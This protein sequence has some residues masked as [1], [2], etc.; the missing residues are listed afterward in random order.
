[1]T[2]M[3]ILYSFAK[4]IYDNNPTS[5]QIGYEGKNIESGATISET[6]EY[7][8]INEGN[9]QNIID[10]IGSSYVLKDFEVVAYLKYNKVGLFDSR[11]ILFQRFIEGIDTTL[12]NS[13]YFMEYDTV[14]SN[15]VQS[16]KKLYIDYTKIESP[17]TA[18]SDDNTKSMFWVLKLT[19]SN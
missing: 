13:F 17:I 19:H 6:E 7:I 4:Y 16:N 5:I 1:M 14:T 3:E 9:G 10:R 12:K 11:E 2:N 8:N 15:F 18:Y